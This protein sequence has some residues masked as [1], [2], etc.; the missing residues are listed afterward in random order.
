M[1]SSTRFF[2]FGLNYT[3]YVC[4]GSFFRMATLV[5][6]AAAAAAST[7][8]VRKANYASELPSSSFSSS[9]GFASSASSTVFNNNNNTNN[10]A[11]ATRNWEE[12]ST[13]PMLASQ[14]PTRKH[15]KVAIIDELQDEIGQLKA[16]NLRLQKRLMTNEQQNE[17]DVSPAVFAA[18]AAASSSSTATT[19]S[20]IPFH[21]HVP[22]S[23]TSINN[24]TSTANAQNRVVV[25]G[26][27]TEQQ[28]NKPVFVLPE[29]V[30]EQQKQSSRPYRDRYSTLQQ[31]QQQ[32]PR[33]PT[34]K[35]STTLLPPPTPTKLYAHHL[36]QQQQLVAVNARANSNVSLPP[37]ATS[38][39][40]QTTTTHYRTESYTST[41]K[42]AT[43]AGFFPQL[44]TKT[45]S[46]IEDNIY[47][48]LVGGAETSS[49]LTT[50]MRSTQYFDS[51]TSNLSKANNS[52]NSNMLTMSKQDE[53]Q[54][55]NMHHAVVQQVMMAGHQSRRQNTSTTAKKS[56]SRSA[57]PNIQHVAPAAVPMTLRMPAILADDSSIDNF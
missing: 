57:R 46:I 44:T 7:T 12:S 20:N 50:T 41:V 8:Y 16:A 48:R 54:L 30:A 11:A 31:Q 19:I 36:P 22:Q 18:A 21:P 52:S 51:T 26:A 9:S 37:I 32:Q 15:Y 1:Q 49:H 14:Q 40:L 4:F 35:H 23:A 38:D 24:T 6:S 13:L 25:W 43:S 56:A 34:R 42:T 53:M 55:D 47:A 45:K 28:T 5:A 10:R 27:E 33:P 2:D 3:P 17:A 29:V 39:N